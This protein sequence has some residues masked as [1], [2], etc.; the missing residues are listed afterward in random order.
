MVIFR[1][2]PCC[3]SFIALSKIVL[4][5]SKLGTSSSGFGLWLTLISFPFNAPD[6][7]RCHTQKTTAG[8]GFN[9]SVQAEG[10]SFNSR[11]LGITLSHG[12]ENYWLKLTA[13]RFDTDGENISATGGEEDGYENQTLSLTSEWQLLIC[14]KCPPV[15]AAAAFMNGRDQRFPTPTPT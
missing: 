4:A 6:R 8:A 1:A 12:A 9:A 15:R 2:S 14:V 13:S 10:G 3:S 5:S 7:R 11:D